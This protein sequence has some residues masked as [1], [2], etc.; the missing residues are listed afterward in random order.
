[1]FADGIGLIAGA[2]KNTAG[3]G[4]VSRAKA[5][6]SLAICPARATKSR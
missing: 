3:S 2:S 1:M 5:T 6:R 4:A